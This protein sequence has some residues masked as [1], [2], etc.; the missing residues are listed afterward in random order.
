MENKKIDLTISLVTYC[1]NEQ[2]VSRL[3]ECILNSQLNF[4]LVILDHSPTP[5]FEYL[6]DSNNN[7]QI[8]YFHNSYNPGF[9]AGHN[10]AFN[11]L[12]HNSNYHLVVNPDIYFNNNILIELLNFLDSNQ[13]VGIVMPK[14][15]Y[16]N[17]EIQKVVKLLPSPFILL[18]R[19]LL[20]IFLFK[21]FNERFEL[22]K[23]NYSYILDVPF[24]SGCFMLI[25]SDIFIKINGFDENIFM[26]T[27]DIDIC[28]RMNNAGYR[29][30]VYP[31]VNVFHDHQIKSIFRLKS[32]I[33]FLKSFL[34]YFN[35]WGWLIDSNR[36][37]LNKITLQKLNYKDNVI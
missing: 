33:I 20:P 30:V 16:P 2:Q 34:Y 31:F 14:I 7:N 3:V 13:N 21:K 36:K 19:R 18:A 28:R 27:E 29:T 5:Q 25:K 24:L 12:T 26:Y 15:C 37:N 17:G 11:H 1:N 35:K 8:L 32:F 22:L 6:K 4:Q 10:N 9:G 23:F